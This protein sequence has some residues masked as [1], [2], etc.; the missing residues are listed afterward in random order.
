MFPP[1]AVHAQ[2]IGDTEDKLLA[3]DGVADDL[4]G[5]SVDIDGTTAIVG[6]RFD[7][8]GGTSSGSAYL[9]DTTTGAELIKL[10]AGDPTSGKEFGFSVGLD[11]TTAVVGA[12]GDDDNGTSSGA[13]Y[14]FDTSTGTELFKL[15]ASDAASNDF[16]GES[17]DV[18]GTT[19]IVG[20]RLSD[21]SSGGVTASG[22]AYIFDTTTGNELFKLT[23]ND[24]AS[25]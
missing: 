8:D 13:A 25:G 14:L 19:A 3:G 18:S 20:S 6:A 23:A 4:Y 17:V 15:T 12:R 21:E 22:S 10:A 2:T 7:D 5:W 24:A 9:Y 16:F 1:V 11:G